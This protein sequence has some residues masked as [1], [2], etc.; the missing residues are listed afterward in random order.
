VAQWTTC[1]RA[2][3]SPEQVLAVLTSP[4][5]IRLWSPID[6]EVGDLPGRRLAAG[7]IARVT[8]SLAGVR[9]GFDVEVHAADAEGIELTAEGP[10]GID[11]R[12]DLQPAVGGSEVCASV[13]L[14]TGSGI[15][16]R[17]LNKATAALL[18]AGALEGAARRIAR[19]AE[20]TP[21]YLLAA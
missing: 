16:G 21:G 11:V 2:S 18:S 7:D 5:A 14:R 17:V 6:F 15:T 20:T 8:G 3:A 12:Y 19:A 4:D 1:T 10:I 9:V 13:S